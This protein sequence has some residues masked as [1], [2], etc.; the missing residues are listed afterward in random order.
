MK[1]HIIRLS[2]SA[3]SI[4]TVAVLFTA[5]QAAGGSEHEH[6]FGKWK[7]SKEAT[8][9]KDGR[10]VREC[11]CGEEEKRTID[12]TGHDFGKWEIA[13]EATCT[14]EGQEVRECDCGEKETK[15]I[16]TT[17]HSYKSEVTQVASCAH[18]GIT[19]YT[20][21]NCDDTYTETAPFQEYSPT[22]INKMY[23]TAVGEIITYDES[24]NEYALGSCFVYSAD[25]KLITNYHVIEH[26]FSIKVTLDGKTYNVKQILAYDKD[27]DVAVLKI[28]ASGLNVAQLCD[29]D[30]AAGE[31]VYAFGNSKGLSSTFS[32]GM[33]TYS[34]R[35]IDGIHYVQHDA[36][37]SSG[38]SGGPLINKYGEVIGINTWTVQDSQNLN[39]AIH[40]SELKNLDF[41]DPLT[42]AEFYEKECNTFVKLK[43]YIVR[44][45]E[46]EDGFYT[47]VLGSSYSSDYSAQYIRMAMY[48][49]SD[50]TMMLVFSID[51][52]TYA[53]FV[54]DRE[55]SGSY[56]WFYFDEYDYEMSGMLYASTFNN[57][58]LLGYNFNN[59]SS[60]D[61]RS[62]VRELASS[63]IAQLCSY[64]NSDFRTAEVTAG[65]LGFIYY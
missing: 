30:H 28:S 3:L 5:C 16:S 10:E 25:G 8:C 19:T 40:I 65:D 59:I 43:N 21:S 52:E 22:E 4:F 46:C 48:D 36:P 6:D 58:I 37:I 9:T 41:S 27:I 13:K 14:E 44:E 33:I 20:C 23:V 56:S 17:G 2:L 61:M 15:A 55:M 31:V 53:G 57:N 62:I 7:V 42:M 12:A 11:D 50:D 18:E 24:G 49:S 47:V 51:A 63:M 39:F 35:K 60:S 64:I 45:G 29:L 32:D 54:L 26:A 38:N 1:R 34:N